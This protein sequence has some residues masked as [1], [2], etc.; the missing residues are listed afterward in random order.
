MANVVI[1]KIGNSIIVDFGNYS[2]LDNVDGQKAS[3]K[4]EDISIIWLEKDE[5]KVYVKMK[6]AITNNIW[7]LSVQSTPTTF[8]IDLINDVAPEDNLDLFD[9]LSALRG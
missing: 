1:N 7:P 3:Y 8:V 2:I 9:K 4:P 5:S 6:D